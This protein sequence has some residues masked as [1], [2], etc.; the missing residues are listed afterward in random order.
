[1]R[2]CTRTTSRVSVSPLVSHS[3]TQHASYKHHHHHIYHNHHQQ[4]MLFSRSCRWGRRRS[5]FVAGAGRGIVVFAPKLMVHAG[6]PPRAPIALSTSTSHL[7]GLRSSSISASAV[8]NAVHRQRPHQQHRNQGWP[9]WSGAIAPSFAVHAGMPQH[10]PAA[11]PL[12][13]HHQSRSIAVPWA[14]RLRSQVGSPSLR[15][16]HTGT[17]ATSTAAAQ[18]LLRARPSAT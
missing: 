6:A 5:A 10:A 15:F 13:R 17:P 7:K 18:R 11:S 12:H 16:T 8:K 9:E 1:M 14:A 2:T 4:L 3:S